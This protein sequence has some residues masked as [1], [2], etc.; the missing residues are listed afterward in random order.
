M[1]SVFSVVITGLKQILV[2]LVLHYC[3]LAGSFFGCPLSF[4]PPHDSRI[5]RHSA[6]RVV[7]QAVTSRPRLLWLCGF[8][9][10]ACL[11]I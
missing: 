1:G 2:C 7:F 3:P 8:L 10:S 6:S 5:D 9:Y 4:S 11:M